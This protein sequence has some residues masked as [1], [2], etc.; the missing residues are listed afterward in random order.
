MDCKLLQRMGA[1]ASTPSAAPRPGWPD[2]SSPEESGGA[3]LGCDVRGM[4]GIP[5]YHQPPPNDL[6]GGVKKVLSPPWAAQRERLGILFQR[7][8]LAVKIKADMLHPHALQIPFFEDQGA[9]KPPIINSNA[10]P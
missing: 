8:S 9:D 3:L 7:F 10:V 1:G 6:S 4:S 5:G 2:S